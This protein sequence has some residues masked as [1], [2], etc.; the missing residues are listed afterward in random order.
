VSDLRDR[1]QAAAEFRTALLSFQRRTTEIAARRGL[2]PQR[3]L[4]LLLIRVRTDARERVTVTSL[5]EPLQMTQSAVTQLALGAEA[6]GLIKR[7]PD[8]GDGRSHSLRLTTEGSRRLRRTFSELSEER[9]TLLAI[10]DA[11]ADAD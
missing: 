5:C 2:T 11:L 3:Y 1:Y 10:M 7:R 4:L 8:P 9:T 6:A